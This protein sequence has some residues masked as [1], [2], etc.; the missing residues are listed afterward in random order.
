MA[1]PLAHLREPFL[2]AP[3]LCAFGGCF[4]YLAGRH[5]ALADIYKGKMGVDKE[6][7]HHLMSNLDFPAA[8]VEISDAA[9]H[10]KAEG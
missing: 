4:C 2:C 3:A 7:A 6:E 5:P 9:A 1:R 10:L 8:V